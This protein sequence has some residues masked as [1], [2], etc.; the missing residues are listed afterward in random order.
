[1]AP[2]HLARRREPIGNC[3][4]SFA[5]LS[6]LVVARGLRSPSISR[7]ND[8]TP[9]GQ[10]SHGGKPRTRS[11]LSCGIS[12]LSEGY[13]TQERLLLTV[14]SMLP[15]TGTYD[16]NLQKQPEHILH[17]PLPCG[18]VS[19]ISE[20]GS[21][22]GHRNPL[23]RNHRASL[24]GTSG[25]GRG[26][27]S[28]ARSCSLAGE[29]RSSAWHSSA[30]EI[31]QMAFFSFAAPGISGAQK[32]TA[33]PVHGL[34]F[35]GHNRRCTARHRQAVHRVAEACLSERSQQRPKSRPKRI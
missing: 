26:T 24:P 10:M 33:N 4:A 2:H 8:S 22:A 3:D 18:L 9:I 14:D 7:S 21:G 1:M 27:G 30:G 11:I 13:N 31:D 5:K 25:R 23:E 28:H 16:R 20:E 15:Y 29:C 12:T 35:C 6:P 34:V 19:E 17:L 32:E